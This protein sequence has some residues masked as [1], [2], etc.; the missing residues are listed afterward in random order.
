MDYQKIIDKYYPIVGGVCDC[1]DPQPP[2][3]GGLRNILMTHSRQV[4]DRCLKIAKAHPELR[5]DEEF[6][7]E[8]AMLHDIG[9]FRCD[10]PSIQCFGTEPYICHGFIGGQILRSEGW[11]RHALVCERHTGTGL[12][13][14]Q[15]ERQHLP[16]PLDGQYEPEALEEQVVCYADKFYSKTHPESERTVVE[17]AQSLEKFGEAGVNRFL[18]WATLFE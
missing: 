15:I 11:V 5:L 16:L 9:I 10:A 13:R 7:E 4:A 18:G 6:L 17:A 14:E 2:N 8:A 1:S 3:L 12:S